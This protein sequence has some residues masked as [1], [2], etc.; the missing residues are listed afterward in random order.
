VGE[1][2]P[3]EKAIKNFDRYTERARKVLA[4]AQEEAR[5]LR[6]NY[7]GT[8]HLLLGL[9]RERD[10][11]GARVLSDLGFG[12]DTFRKNVESIIGRGATDVSGEVSMTPRTKRV[13]ELAVDEANQ[14]SHAYV[15]TEH[16]L[17][18]LIRE[19][20][21]IGAHILHRLGIGTD[22]VRAEVL[23]VLSIGQRPT[24]PAW[25]KDNVVTCRVDDQD[26]DAIDALVE[27]GLRGSRS[28]AASWL[29]RAGIEANQELFEK[30]YTAVAE[31]RRLR[32]DILLTAMSTGKVKVISPSAA[33]AA[34][35]PPA[36]NPPSPSDNSVSAD[37]SD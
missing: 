22:R 14:L 3:E 17:L 33:T 24:E 19:G 27:A 20:D 34:T 18:G 9:A 31:I 4:N 1:L 7:L 2:I 35:D 13:L 6:H 11:V 15:G 28:D 23:R 32:K 8:E 30:V 16:L 21:G 26:L 12:L 37:K 25:S 36:A 29:V 10:G 5:R